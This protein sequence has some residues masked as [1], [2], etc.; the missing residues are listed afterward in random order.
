MIKLLLC[1]MLSLC[2]LLSSLE[3]YRERLCEAQ[4]PREMAEAL[5]RMI[6]RLRFDAEDVFSLCENSFDGFVCADFS[7]FRAISSGDFH[8]K[9]ASACK[10]L[11]A[12]RESKALFE[13][14]GRILGSCDLQTQTERLAEISQELSERSKKLRERAEGSKRLY[15]AFGALS[16]IGISLMIM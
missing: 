14:A 11:A 1:A 9:W 8:K 7:E 6:S 2:T 15:T 5:S 12:D 10:N 13:S 16:G 3:M 4:I